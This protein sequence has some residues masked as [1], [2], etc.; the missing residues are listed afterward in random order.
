MFAH[1]TQMS[2]HAVPTLLFLYFGENQRAWLKGTVVSL[3]E[4]DIFGV[5]W[6]FWWKWVCYDKM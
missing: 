4:V 5:L 1:V 6:I 2:F 3:A